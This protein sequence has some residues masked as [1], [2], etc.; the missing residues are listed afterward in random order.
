MSYY[1]YIDLIISIYHHISPGGSCRLMQN[2]RDA[3]SL[4]SP[5]HTSWLLFLCEEVSE[6][7][8]ILNSLDRAQMGLPENRIIG[9]L[10]LEYIVNIVIHQGISEQSSS[11]F[12]FSDPQ[13]LSHGRQNVPFTISEKSACAMMRSHFHLH[14][15]LSRGV[16]S[17]ANWCLVK[18]HPKQP[19]RRAVI[20]S[21][22]PQIIWFPVLD[23]PKV[24]FWC[25]HYIS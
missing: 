12:R 7:A 15:W 2:L 1:E 3:L 20:E 10:S 8:G 14:W 24:T 13:S 21:F 4:T 25:F 17:W 16:F 18:Y 22:D 19:V 9:S 6:K 5:I 11:I 23:L